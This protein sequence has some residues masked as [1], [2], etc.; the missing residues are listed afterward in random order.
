MQQVDDHRYAHELCA[1][2]RYASLDFSVSAEVNQQF[3][4]ALEDYGSDYLDRGTGRAV[5]HPVLLLHMSARTRSPSFRLAPGT[6]SVFAKD[7]VRFHR[8]A[9]V[10]QR[11]RVDWTIREVYERK[12]RLYQALDTR[13]TTAS[14]DAVLVRDAH[15]VFF[16]RSGEPLNLPP[17]SMHP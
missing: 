8:P 11:L 14:G 4:F 2:E 1:G 12:G 5:V 13:V 15:S 7:R 17:A 10:D 6:G 3:L 9:F 16:T